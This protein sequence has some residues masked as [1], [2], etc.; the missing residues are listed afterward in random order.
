MQLYTYLYLLVPLV[1]FHLILGTGTL[2]HGGALTERRSTD[3]TAL[4]PEPVLQKSAARS[5]D[6]NGKDRLTQM[7]RILKKRGKN[8][9]GDEE[10]SKFIEREREAGRLDLS[11]FP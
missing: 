8:A 9:R 11:K 2:D 7:K 4:K 5:T 3:A 6:D 1:T 10:Y